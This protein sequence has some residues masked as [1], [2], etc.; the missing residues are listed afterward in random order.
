MSEDFILIDA[1]FV[2]ASLHRGVHL[3][4]TNLLNAITNMHDV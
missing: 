4:L 2:I 1:V 3:K